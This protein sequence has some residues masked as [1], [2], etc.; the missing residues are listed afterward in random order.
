MS[1]SRSS[2][3][4]PFLVMSHRSTLPRALAH[5]TSGPLAMS[6]TSSQLANLCQVITSISR[7]CPLPVLG[8]A[9][10]SRWSAGNRDVSSTAIFV[11][12]VDQPAVLDSFQD[13]V[14]RLFRTGVLWLVEHD[15]HTGSAVR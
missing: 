9:R 11:D 14:V 7:R 12:L 1:S 3:G 5:A 10:L 13:G 15:H 4:D 2:E 6:H 8:F